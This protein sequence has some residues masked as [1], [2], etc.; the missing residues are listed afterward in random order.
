MPPATILQKNGIHFATV[1]TVI[2]SKSVRY[3]FIRW[4]LYKHKGV[5]YED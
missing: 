4:I 2:K 1:I 5:L 3:R